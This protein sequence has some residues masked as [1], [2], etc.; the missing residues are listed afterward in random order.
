MLDNVK[1]KVSCIVSNIN[2]LQIQLEIELIKS[3]YLSEVVVRAS[4]LETQH[5][6]R[7]CKQAS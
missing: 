7:L 5:P 1:V 3:L 6:L 2:G 4:Y